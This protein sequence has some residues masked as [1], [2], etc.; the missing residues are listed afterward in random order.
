MTPFQPNIIALDFETS[1]LRYWEPDYRVLSAAFAWRGK[2]GDIRTKYTEGEHET[3]RFLRKIADGSIGITVHNLSF[4]YGVIHYRYP[5]LH[6]RLNFV[7]DTMRLLQVADNGGEEDYGLEGSIEDEMAALEGFRRSKTGL[8]LEA[9]VRR[10]LS[11][12]LHNHKEPFYRWLRDNG[13]QR[14]QEGANLDKLP[15]ELFI[16]YNVLDSVRTLQLYEA[17]TTE[18]EAAGYD[19]AFDHKLY[20]FMAK[21][22][23]HA[24]GRGIAVERARGQ[25]YAEQ[26]A[27]DIAAI[28]AEFRQEFLSHIRRIEE[29]STEAWIS[30][31]TT[32]A[33]RSRRRAKVDSGEVKFEFNINSTRQLEAL[34]CGRLGFT[35][36][37]LTPK[38]RP[39]FAAAFSS[40][41]GR[42]GELLG[43]RKSKLLSLKQT[44]NLL[45]LA[46]KDGRWHLNLKP[47]G[48][49]TGRYAGGRQ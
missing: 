43:N 26:V 32:D 2:D 17:L 12:D 19:W 14:G 11:A 49:K 41:W 22:I 24:Q 45:A 8:S 15:K 28:D 36:K 21:Q 44:E 13:V 47:C 20:V 23:A 27:R 46:E 5:G 38:G 39:S 31:P 10:H 25:A 6:G 33:G 1:G 3:E 4:E 30:A 35:P 40:Q 34:F 29:S 7:A 9:G 42:G 48:T 18:F 16:D 37:F